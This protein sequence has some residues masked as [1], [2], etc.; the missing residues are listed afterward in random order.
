[1][2]Y[3]E[4]WKALELFNDFEPTIG[5][6]VVQFTERLEKEASIVF[7]KRN[8]TLNQLTCKGWPNIQVEFPSRQLEE[9]D[10]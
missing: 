8:L 6:I 3:G 1:M 2:G 7:V 10:W 5:K 4:K 9:L